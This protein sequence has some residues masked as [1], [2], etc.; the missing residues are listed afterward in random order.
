MRRKRVMAVIFAACMVST[1]L[2]GCRVGDTEIRIEGRQLNNQR[3]IFEVN[4]YKCSIK[5]AKLYLCNYR[6]LYGEAYGQDLWQDN[7]QELEAYV[8]DV[9]IQELSHIVCMELLAREQGMSLTEEEQKQMQAAA[10]AYYDSLKEEEISYMDISEKDVEEAYMQY[11]LA[12]KLYDSLTEDNNE[13]ISD[14]EALVI[15][16]QQ[17][18]VKDKDTADSI[19]QRL[20]AGEEFSAIAGA[21]S[22]SGEI[23][24]TVARGDYPQEVENIAFNL[25]DNE[26]SDMVE[27]DG[28]YYFIKCIS[29]FEEELTELNKEK[30]RIN[31]EKEQFEDS[32]QS[33]V[34]A[35][36]FR[37]NEELWKKVSLQDTS[38]ITT[39]SFFEVF[40]KYF[41]PHH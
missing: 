12:Q 13:E 8:K 29:K 39:D 14:D 37:M 9:T 23:E 25:E 7:D 38:Y 1:V 16:V 4:D 31:R 10:K 36:S 2:T 19:Q 15:R 34:D 35:S 26:V 3:T 18:C 41:A 21:Y 33:F 20:A 24:K 17:I 5:Q 40:E 22:K 27:A 6:N 32:Y 28:S 11:A 30:I